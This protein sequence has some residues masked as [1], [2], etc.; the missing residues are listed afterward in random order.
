MSMPFPRFKLSFEAFF[1]FSVCGKPN[2][3]MCLPAQLLEQKLCRP[4]LTFLKY[5]DFG[6]VN[7]RPQKSQV[8]VSSFL[9]SLYFCIKLNFVG[10]PRIERGLREPKPLVT[11]TTPYS[12]IVADVGLA[13][14]LKGMNLVCDYHIASAMFAYY[15]SQ[16]L[17]YKQ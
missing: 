9:F 11:T 10:V 1:C 17:G 8:S 7:S 12:K 2:V 5:S 3:C 14:H 15:I 4:N 16:C 13:P 6:F